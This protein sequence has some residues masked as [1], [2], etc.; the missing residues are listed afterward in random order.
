M[1]WQVFQLSPKVLII[2]HMSTFLSHSCF[3]HHPLCEFQIYSQI[4][5]FYHLVRY[6]IKHLTCNSH[7]LLMHLIKYLTCKYNQLMRDLI[8]HLTCI[9][10]IWT[11]QTQIPIWWTN[12]ITMSRI[13]CYLFQWSR[14]TISVPFEHERLST[15]IFVSASEIRTITTTGR[16]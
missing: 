10:H 5:S 3:Q 13:L 6:L 11:T 9:S 14:K 1:T 7:H 15:W 2:S 16:R 12:L 4:F 8:R